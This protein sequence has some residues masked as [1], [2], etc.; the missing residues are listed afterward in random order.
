MVEIIWTKQAS[1]ELELIFNYI[2]KDSY[3]YAES[4]VENILQSI[5]T[6]E[7]FPKIGRIVP[8]IDDPDVRE[9]IYTKYRIMY[10]INED[11][12]EILSIIHG[13][14]KYWKI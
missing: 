1:E 12:V 13:S 5:E 8:E 6:L 2:K 4:F 11:H 14:R 9:I 7:K 10:R 3:F